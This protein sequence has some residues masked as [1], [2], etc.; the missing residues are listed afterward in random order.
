METS[1]KSVEE[2]E[3]IGIELALKNRV[4]KDKL[5]NLSKYLNKLIKEL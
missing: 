1:K 3:K 2:L 5:K 4:A